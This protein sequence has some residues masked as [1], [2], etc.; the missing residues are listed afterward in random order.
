M[1]NYDI[2]KARRDLYAPKHGVFVVVEVPEL[3][4]LQIDGHGDPNTS[5]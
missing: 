4:Y 3:W 5:K 2:K 1:E